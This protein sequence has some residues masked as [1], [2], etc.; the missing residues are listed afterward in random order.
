MFEWI[1]VHII[2]VRTEIFLIANQMLPITAL[3]YA[4]FTACYSN[5]GAPL[6]NG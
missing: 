2:Q 1:D 3:P 5:L 4:P 6:G